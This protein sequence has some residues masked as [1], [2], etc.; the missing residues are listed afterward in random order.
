MADV[1][2][3]FTGLSNVNPYVPTAPWTNTGGNAGQIVGG[4]YQYATGTPGQSVLWNADIPTVSTG[5]IHVRASM[6]TVTTT[7]RGA[8]FAD[9][10]GN[11]YQLMVN[12][13]TCRI[14]L[15]TAWDIGAQLGADAASPVYAADDVFDFYR[16]CDTGV[17]RIA[18]EGV[19]IISRTSNVTTANMRAGVF[20]RGNG[21]VGVFTYVDNLVA[22]ENIGLR[23]PVK[24]RL[25]TLPANDTGYT[26]VVRVAATS[27]AILYQTNTA[28]IVDGFIE[29]DDDA[30]G[31]VDDEVHVTIYKAGASA[32]LDKNAAGRALVVDLETE[33]ES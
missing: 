17:M 4:G 20:S 27:T 2:L 32:A 1:I 22:T 9:A 25:G 26:A 8:A 33:D 19:D 6:R 16:D 14:F 11:G 30:V 23:I 13:A 28:A 29:L 24:T 18:F 5:E 31:D 21:P 3:D 12:S 15:M 10:S 7:N